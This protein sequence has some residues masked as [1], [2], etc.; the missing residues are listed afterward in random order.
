[1]SPTSVSNPDSAN[2]TLEVTADDSSR[3]W[4]LV[5]HMGDMDGVLGPCFSLAQSGPM[6]AFGE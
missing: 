1:M 2:V 5:I 6:Q 3:T 4:I